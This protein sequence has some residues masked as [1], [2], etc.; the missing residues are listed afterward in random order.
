MPIFLDDRSLLTAFRA[1]HAAAFERVYA[2][3]LDDVIRLIRCGFVAGEARVAGVPDR[4][5]QLDTAHDVFARAFEPRARD[6]YDGLRPYG[7]YLLR[8]GKNLIIDRFRKS[9]RERPLSDLELDEA[10]PMDPPAEDALHFATLR[11]ATTEFL[12][13]CDDEL[14]RFVTWR[15]EESGSQADVAKRMGITRR[16]VRTLEERAREGLRRHLR[17]KR[18]L[19]AETER[20]ES[21]RTT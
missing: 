19:D 16:R 21:E 7:P 10:E 5:Q 12:A 11:Q 9:G 18:L 1:G 8:I 4:S 13:N 15:F 2:F 6:G 20:P 3:Y 14:R 17:E